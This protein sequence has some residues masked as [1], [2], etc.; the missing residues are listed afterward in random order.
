MDTQRNLQREADDLLREARALPLVAT[1][2]LG[3]TLT[4]MDP[5]VVSGGTCLPDSRL[6]T[7]LKPVTGADAIPCT[8][9]GRIPK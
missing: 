3:M 6:P 5:F 7:L 2:G 9:R 1:T 8:S 4:N